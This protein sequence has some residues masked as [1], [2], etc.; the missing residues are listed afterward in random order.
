MLWILIV[1]LSEIKSYVVVKQ[2]ALQACSLK[3]RIKKAMFSVH[4]K[5]DIFKSGWG[6]ETYPPT[7]PPSF[8]YAPE[9][10]KIENCNFDK[11]VKLTVEIFPLLDI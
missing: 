10:Y 1:Q 9:I 4:C 6:R 8:G 2:G 7:L 3:H 5:L 11:H